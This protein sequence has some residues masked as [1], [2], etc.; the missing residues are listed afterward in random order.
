MATGSSEEGCDRP[1]G[2][3]ES[4]I[5]NIAIDETLERQVIRSRD[6]TSR[7]GLGLVVDRW[8][9]TLTQVLTEHGFSGAPL[10]R[11]KPRRL[12]RETLMALQRASE[13]TGVHMPDLLRACMRLEAATLA[14]TPVPGTDPKREGA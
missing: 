8:L 12:Y 4:V 1:P 14:E 3:T 2:K 7:V 11:R 13:L 6:M 10:G 5:A 9:P